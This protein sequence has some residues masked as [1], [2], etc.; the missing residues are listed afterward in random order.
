MNR[1]ASKALLGTMEAELKKLGTTPAQI[2]TWVVVVLRPTQQTGGTTKTG[3]V[4]LAPPTPGT[5]QMTL[6]AAQ[7]E[8]V[9]EEAAQF[10]P[11]FCRVRASL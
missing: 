7:E 11:Y 9:E 4:A 1:T 2:L 10:L 6:V 5:K 8:A 3:T